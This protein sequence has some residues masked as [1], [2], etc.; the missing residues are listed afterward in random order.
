MQL[1]LA[2]ELAQQIAEQVRSG[3]YASD[4]EVVEEALRLLFA[5]D[6]MRARLRADIQ[7]GLDQLDRGDTI[8]GEALFAEIDELLQG[9]GRPV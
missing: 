2:P 5:T 9:Y 6:A 7:I 4:R 3:R 1:T 8:S